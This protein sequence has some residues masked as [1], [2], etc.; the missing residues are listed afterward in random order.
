MRI[1]IEPPRQ[2]D[3]EALLAGSAAYAL[4]LYPAGSCYLLE[5]SELEAPGVEV[6]VVRVSG[7]A[8]GTGSL[9]ARGDGTAELKRLY[10]DDRAR[11]QGLATALLERIEQHA[12]A[13]GVRLLQLETGPQSL[14]AI[15]LYEK[16]GYSRIP[17]FE[18]YGGDPH[19]YCMEKAL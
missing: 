19:S 1:A 3:V 9:V 13:T 8:L 11:G 10:V 12:A 16:H 5:V 18:P 7:V 14:P 15:G 2:P 4:L 6:F 17:N